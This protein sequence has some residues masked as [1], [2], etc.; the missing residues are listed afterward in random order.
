MNKLFK[1]ILS[2]IVLIAMIIAVYIILHMNILPNK[3]LILFF[4]VEIV[5]YLLGLFFYNR[6]N[7]FLLVL[8]V[9]LFLLSLGVNCVVYYYFGK[10][11]DYIDLVFNVKTYNVT[12]KYVLLTGANNKVSSLDNLD[13]NTSILFYEY[14]RG[15]N[16]ATKKLGNYN[17]QKTN[18]FYGSLNKARDDN[19]YF[20][21]SKSDYSFIMDASNELSNDQF[22]IIKEFE[23]IEKVLINQEIPDSYNIYINGLDYSG[24]RRDFNMIAT[25]NTKTNKIVLTSIPRDYYIYVPDYDMEDSLTALGTVDPEISKR[26]LERLLNTKIDYVLNIYTESLVKVV[27]ALGG[28]EFCSNSSF[29]TTHDMTLG[30][31]E[32]NN[33]KLYVTK[34]C[35]QY[36]GLEALAIARERLH[37]SSGDRARQEN[38]RKILMSIL[39]KLASTT[40]LTNYNEVLSSFDGLYTSNINKRV[41]TN[42]VKSVLDNPNYEIIEQSLDGYDGKGIG[43]LG[44]G[45]VWAMRPNENTV[46]SASIKINEVLN[47]N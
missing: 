32:D 44:S 28:I 1:N 27:D 30:S 42:L 2:I 38:C 40:T 45:E 26:A 11:S 24:N 37:Y 34:G 18:D 35:R 25:I 10:T 31:Y 23:V 15:V 43:R 13:N 22:K 8:G 12:T 33:S 47:S 19:L 39:K 7:I 9:F 5:L 41:I 16:L 14:S 17:Y 29:Y 6:K 46:N 20:L 4:V 21:I 36:N 3:Y